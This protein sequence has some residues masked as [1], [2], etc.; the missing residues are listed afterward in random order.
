MSTAYRVRRLKLKP[1]DPLDRLAHASGALYSQAL[2]YFWRVVRKK[3]IWHALQAG[4]PRL[5][6]QLAVLARSPP[7]IFSILCTSNRADPELMKEVHTAI[8]E[9]PQF[10][11]GQE[12]LKTF[13]VDDHVPFRDEYLTGIRQLLDARKQRLAPDQID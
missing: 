8:L 3:G 2:V 7:L 11:E 9:L 13:G 1:T 5:G 10:P 12:L 4:D 6:A